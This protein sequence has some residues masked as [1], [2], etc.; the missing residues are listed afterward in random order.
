MVHLRTALE[1]A[2]SPVTFVEGDAGDAIVADPETRVQFPVP[3]DGVL[4]AIINEPLLHWAWSGPALEVVGRASF[5]ITTSSE[6]DAQLLVMV[7]LSVTDVDGATPVIVVV[8]EDGLVITALP[9]IIVQ[10][11]VPETGLLPAIVNVDV[12]QSV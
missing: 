1:P 8:G 4:A 11:P 10:F 6:L 3:V 7:H 9:E 12:L 5:W 2:A